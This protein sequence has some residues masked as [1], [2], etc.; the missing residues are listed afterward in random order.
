MAEWVVMRELLSAG[1]IHP[2]Q[3]AESLGMTR[4]A[5]SKLVGRL[6]AKKLVACRAVKGDQRYQSVELTATGRKLVPILALLA[7]QNDA[8][9]FGH[10]SAEEH[11]RLM[12]LLKDIVRR[13]GLKDI[14][15]N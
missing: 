6:S 12:D 13:N 8:E 1:D 9:F 11:T 7:D 4:G 5:I 2:S 15:V 14:P 3:L 10:L